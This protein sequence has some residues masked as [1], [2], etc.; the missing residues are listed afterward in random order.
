MERGTKESL[1]V[2]TLKEAKR[3][4][5]EPREPL[6]VHAPCTLDKGVERW[7]EEGLRKR[8][9]AFDSNLPDQ[10]G[11]W[12][13]ASGAATRMFAPVQSTDA[14]E[15]LWEHRKE[16]AFGEA[17]EREHASFDGSL[18]ASFWSVVNDG[19]LPKALVPF[20]QLEE[21]GHESALA[22]HLRFWSEVLGKGREGHVRFTVQQEHREAI[23]QA[24]SNSTKGV[25]LS[26]TLETQDPQTDPLV[27]L[28]DGSWLST[29]DGDVFK[30]PGGHGALLAN[31]SATDRGMVV[32]R[33]IDNAPSPAMTPLRVRWTRAMVVE[34]QRWSLECHGLIDDLRKGSSGSEGRALAWLKPF[35]HPS[36]FQESWGREDLLALLNRPMRLVGVV[37]NNGQRGG[38]P[39][40]VSHSDASGRRLVTAQIVESVEF[41]ESNRAMLAESTYFNPVDMVC[42]LGDSRNYGQWMDESRHLVSIKEI[43]GQ[44]V[45]VLEH[46]GLWNGAMAGWLTRFVELPLACFQPV[47]TVMDLVGR[48]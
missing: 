30:R 26:V 22:A 15:R 16:L 48:H 27:L 25:S 32:I 4:L 2:L 21:G 35:M 46:P 29:D 28:S 31:L 42:V 14:I 33:N 40:W 20:H 10:L 37:T 3:K 12:V 43:A 45:R 17:W 23:E 39:F 13:P 34:A 24:A 19:D 6:N 18:E 5:L 47:K 11:L 7:T 9:Q 38:G 1:F 44:H 8:A 36:N 41:D